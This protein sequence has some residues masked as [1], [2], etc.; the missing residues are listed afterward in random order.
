MAKLNISGFSK[1]KGD[2]IAVDV[3]SLLSHIWKVVWVT[4]YDNQNL[5]YNIGLEYSGFK[6]TVTVDKNIVGRMVTI[7]SEVFPPQIPP[8]EHKEQFLIEN[9]QTIVR[10]KMVLSHILKQTAYRKH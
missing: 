5:P 3:N 8:V 6:V 9:F 2:E 1:L 10:M 7:T 4:S